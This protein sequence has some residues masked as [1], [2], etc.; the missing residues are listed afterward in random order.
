MNNLS[1]FIQNN[2]YTIST[3]ITIP[4]ELFKQLC[5][6]ANL[7]PPAFW[8]YSYSTKDDLAVGVL[9]GN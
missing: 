1:R 5:N 8:N 3:D 7:K 6:L 2:Y 4:V 9:D